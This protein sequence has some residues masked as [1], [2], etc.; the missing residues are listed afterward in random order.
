[1]IVVSIFLY[2]V[3]SLYETTSVSNARLPAFSDRAQ[4]LLVD[5][6]KQLDQLVHQPPRYAQRG[7]IQHF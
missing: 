7:A 1:M 5:Q 3:S 4:E 6:I 2:A